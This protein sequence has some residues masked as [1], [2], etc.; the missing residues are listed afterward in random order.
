MGLSY[1]YSMEAV[2]EVDGQRR[3]LAVLEGRKS[4]SEAQ[5][6]GDLPF[7]NGSIELIRKSNQLYR[8]DA[9]EDRWVKVPLVNLEDL[10]TLMVEINPLSIFSFLDNTAV[11]YA[12][13]GKVDGRRC[14]IYEA[15][16]RGEN[17]WLTFIWQDYNY[18]IWVDQKEGYLKQGEITAEHR[19]DS[20][21][22]LIV[23]VKIK[24]YNQ[25]LTIEAPVQN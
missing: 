24:D 5:I 13:K 17:M 22:R 14:R 19:D 9:L 25:P 7:I 2:E 6:S 3:V 11:E 4:G 12:G 23:T 21:H 15:M 16:S 10:E 1:S 20:T 18:R 8:K